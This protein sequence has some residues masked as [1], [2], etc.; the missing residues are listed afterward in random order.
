MAF[1]EFKLKFN[2]F[3]KFSKKKAFDYF[4]DKKNN[5]IN[6]EDLQNKMLGDN[7]DSIK[8]EEY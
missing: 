7:L 8:S 4:D 3:I 5:F 1:K 2:F 6:V